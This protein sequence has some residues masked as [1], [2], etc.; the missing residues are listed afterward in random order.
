MNARILRVLTNVSIHILVQMYTTLTVIA[1]GE[2]INMIVI[3]VMMIRNHHTH[4]RKL[5]K[6]M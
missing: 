4:Q 5:G 6:H 3:V 1:F 2:N